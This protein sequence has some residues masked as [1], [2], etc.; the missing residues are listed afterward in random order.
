M[1]DAATGRR[2]HPVTELVL[3]GCALLLVY[4]VDSPVV[5]ALLVIAATLAA[6][7]SPH[8]RVLGWMLT[9]AA[10]T[11]SMLIMAGI[12]QG[13]FS[14]DPDATVLW[15]WGPFEAT[16]QGLAVAGQLWLRLVATVA[17]CTL[18][19]FASDTTRVFDGLVA[20][21]APVQ[22]AAVCA[23][24]M[25]LMPELRAR[26]D[27]ALLAR[28]ARGWPIRR[29]GV[30]LR[31]MPGILAGLLTAA[32]VQADER[33]EV[34][35]WRGLGASAHPVPLRDH[36]DGPVQR[37]FRRLAPVLTA[38]T[39]IASVAGALPLPGTAELLHVWGVG[40][41]HA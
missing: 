35:A 29:L 37:W 9:V 38:A 23:S 16:I 2:L 11:G 39:V 4:G 28:A 5:P 18:F 13:L 8:V 22:I 7:L 33:R 32:L 10:L 1:N 3:L 24:A 31:A 36:A 6:I 41:P 27:A 20:L 19:G 25:N 14:P 21:H 40:G 34:L 30:R 26:A 12:V 17:V 15:S